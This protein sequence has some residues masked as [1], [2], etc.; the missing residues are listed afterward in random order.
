MLRRGASHVSIH[1]V[2]RGRSGAGHHPRRLFAGAPLRQA[3]LSGA[4]GVAAR[5]RG[6]RRAARGGRPVAR[7]LHRRAPARR[8][9]AG[10]GQQPR[11][12]H[13]DVECRAGA[14]LLPDPA[15]RVV[16]GRERR[17]QRLV[18][19][20]PRGGGARR[21]GLHGHAVQRGPRRRRL[22]ARLLRPHSKPQGVGPRAV[23][24]H[25]AGSGGHPSLPRG[26]RRPGLSRPR[27]RRREPEAW[28]GHAG[29]PAVVAGAHPEEPRPWHRLG[30]SS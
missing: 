26:R 14:G 6:R 12:A 18:A 7:L 17:R 16:P 8:H 1:H 13:G 28:E 11:S 19:A 4:A 2:S 23:P 10:A 25:R 3:A 24:R 5:G 20:H 30:F 29:G 22:G 9:R 15:R 27:G 21:Q